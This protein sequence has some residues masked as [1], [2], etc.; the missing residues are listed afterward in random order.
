MRTLVA[1]HLLLLALSGA[2]ASCAQTDPY[3]RPGEWHPL[4]ANAANLRAMAADP[5][6]LYQGR[7]SA[8]QPGDIAAAAVAR[9]RADAVK[10]LPASAISGIRATDIG[11]S[12]AGPGNEATAAAPVAAPAAAPAAGAGQ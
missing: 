7:A 9:L 8:D 4:G 12:A 2:L 1:C 6:D 11:P 10:R 3:T 5:R